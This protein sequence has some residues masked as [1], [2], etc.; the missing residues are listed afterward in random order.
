MAHKGMS[1]PLRL[2]VIII[3]LLVA[4]FLV[5]AVFS[6]GLGNIQ[7]QLD[8]MFSWLSDQPL[9]NTD[10]NLAKQI[11]IQNAFGIEDVT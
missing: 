2:V 6:G 8:G 1:M 3:V 9:S 4:A 10:N 11:D 5:L 7:K